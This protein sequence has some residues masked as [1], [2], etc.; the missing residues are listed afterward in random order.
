MGLGPQDL[1]QFTYLILAPIYHI[2]K[3]LRSGASV[4]LFRLDIW[5]RLDHFLLMTHHTQVEFKLPFPNEAFLVTSIT[6][7]NVQPQVR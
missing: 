4:V 3:H 2:N 5:F 6:R 1:E 7:T